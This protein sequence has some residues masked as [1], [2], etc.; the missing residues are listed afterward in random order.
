MEA[1]AWAQQNATAYLSSP[2]QTKQILTNS[3]NNSELIL[4]VSLSQHAIGKF[5]LNPAGPIRSDEKKYSH[6]EVSNLR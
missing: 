2:W 6:V 3:L 4:L 5:S 1:L